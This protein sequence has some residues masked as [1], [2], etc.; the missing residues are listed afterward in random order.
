MGMCYEY[1]A[2]SRRDFDALSAGERS[3][4]DEFEAGKSLDIDKAWHS[5]HFLLTGAAWEAD[6]LIFGG[7]EIG[8]DGDDWGYGPPR[9]FRPR[10]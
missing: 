1:L 6:G 10:R 9:G 5:I 2:L 8:E 3:V 4:R 7:T